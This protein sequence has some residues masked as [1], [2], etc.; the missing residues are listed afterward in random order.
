MIPITGKV[1]SST[2]MT[3]LGVNQVTDDGRQSVMLR[4]DIRSC[5]VYH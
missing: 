4:T 2:H 5:S 3:D 1:R